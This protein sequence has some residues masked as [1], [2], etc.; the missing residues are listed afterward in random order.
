M[1]RKFYRPCSTS[2]SSFLLPTK[3]AVSLRDSNRDCAFPVPDTRP[4]LL[5]PANVSRWFKLIAPRAWHCRQPLPCGISVHGAPILF[6]GI[7]LSS[8]AAAFD[9]P[10]A[11]PFIIVKVIAQFR[12]QRHHHHAI[13]DITSRR[14]GRLRG[15]C[16][17]PV[18]IPMDNS[19]AVQNSPTE[20]QVRQMLVPH[21]P[22]V[23]Q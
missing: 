3:P 4:C 10:P 2:F 20:F 18:A 14:N 7:R 15:K 11:V 6:P 5:A 12:C 17:V 13:D 23:G 1:R 21:P 9:I 8:T 19:C 22:T 16:H